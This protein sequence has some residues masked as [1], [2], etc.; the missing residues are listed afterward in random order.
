MTYPNTKY[1]FGDFVLQTDG[2]LQYKEQQVN[3]PPKELAVLTMLLEYAGELVTKDKLLDYAW[4]SLEVSDE[5]LTRCIYA[6]RKAL[7]E[8]K[9][10]R[11]IDTVYGKGYRFCRPV[12]SIALTES[13]PGQCSIALLPFHIN[14]EIDTHS[15]HDAL[16]QGLSLYAS[17]GFTVLPAVIT[18][19]CN[20]PSEIITLIEMVRPDY[21]LAGYSVISSGKHLLRIELVQANNHQLVHRE[22]LEIE[23]HLDIEKLQQ[24]L[25]S[26]IPRHIPSLNWACHEDAPL[27]SQNA[28]VCYLNARYDLHSQSNLK[29]PQPAL[30]Q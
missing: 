5:S 10:N 3:I 14:K 24:D 12:A 16:I 17:Y 29:H 27:S 25:V 7:F 23:V 8:D 26:M 15:L 2:V 6:L 1:T 18:Q 30:K 20:L 13:N 21:Y 28:T 9:N 22:M 19:S 4:S 11:Y